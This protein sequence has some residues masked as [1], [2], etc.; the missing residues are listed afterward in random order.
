M[1]KKIK[2]KWNKWLLNRLVTFTGL[3]LRPEPGIWGVL[4]QKEE[5]DVLAE[6]YKNTLFI[7]LLKKYAEGN[8]KNILAT[9]R[10][11]MDY[12]KELGR[13]L[14]FNGLILKSRRAFQNK[15]KK[16]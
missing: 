10:L 8:V 7:S 14:A 5:D 16:V 4:T 13:F 15:S 12:G 11:D 2:Q 9:S 1:F 6:L 3:D